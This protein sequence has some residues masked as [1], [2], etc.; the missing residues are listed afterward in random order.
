MKDK[1]KFIY[2]TINRYLKTDFF[3]LHFINILLAFEEGY[4]KRL[5]QA[6]EE[7]LNRWFFKFLNEFVEDEKK[8]DA[9]RIEF[10]TL[11]IEK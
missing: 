4:N 1:I 6:A 7:N 5:L 2:E 3:K 10:V 11:F 9:L 8:R